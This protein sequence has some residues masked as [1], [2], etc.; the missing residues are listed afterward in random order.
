[1]PSKSTSPFRVVPCEPEALAEW[2]LRALGAS[3]LGQ[4]AEVQ[5][6]VAIAEASSFY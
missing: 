3:Q 1:M 5:R 4:V 6:L 2:V